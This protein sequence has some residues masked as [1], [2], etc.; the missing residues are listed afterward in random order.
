MKN[1]WNSLHAPTK[2]TMQWK[3]TKTNSVDIIGIGVTVPL[4]S[5]FPP[6]LSNLTRGSCDVELY[7]WSA[8]QVKASL[9]T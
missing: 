1:A 5:F 4:L 7:L 3:N 8:S 9:V 6:H 2:V